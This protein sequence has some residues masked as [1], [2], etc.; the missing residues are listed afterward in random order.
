[1]QHELIGQFSQSSSNCKIDCSPSSF[2]Q[3]SSAPIITSSASYSCPESLTTSRYDRSTSGLPAVLPAA[4]LDSIVHSTETFNFGS[5]R[6]S[7]PKCLLLSA[8]CLQ[9]RRYLFSSQIKAWNCAKGLRPAYLVGTLLR[10]AALSCTLAQTQSANCQAVIAQSN[11][12]YTVG[13]NSPALSEDRTE[14]LNCLTFQTSFIKSCS[15]L[16]SWNV[17][18]CLSATVKILEFFRPTPCRAAHPYPTSTTHA[19]PA[20]MN[21]VRSPEEKPF[22]PCTIAW[23]AI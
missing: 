23:P 21:Y 5:G 18:N 8:M 10:I 17:W 3:N 14:D 2:A 9:M 11:A 13:K 22:R 7:T 16:F 15:G 1:M 19:T 4:N 12:L 20:R 6:W